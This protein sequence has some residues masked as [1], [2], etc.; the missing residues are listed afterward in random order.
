MLYPA[1]T[2]NFCV[3]FR[4]AFSRSVKVDGVSQ[5]SHVT[6]L[7]LIQVKKWSPGLPACSVFSFAFSLGTHGFR[8]YIIP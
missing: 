1:S 7:T 4:L 6:R 3:C 2:E 8:L 5:V